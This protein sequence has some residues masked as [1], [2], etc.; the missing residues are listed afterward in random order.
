MTDLWNAVA[1]LLD[2]DVNVYRWECDVNGCD[3][4]PHAGNPSPHG[5]SEQQLPEGEWTTWLLQAGRGFGKSRTGAESLLTLIL[6]HPRTVDDSPTEW[7]VAGA[8][9]PDTREIMVVGPSGL[10][11]AMQRRG[12]Q[13]S[14]NRSNGLITLSSGQRVHL[15]SGDDHDL[16]RGM[17]LAGAWVD[18]V[19]TWRRGFSAW[20]EG[21]IPA[22][23]QRLSNDRPRIIAT[24]TPKA[25]G[26]KLLKSLSGRDD[27]SVVITRGSTFA[28]AANLSSEAVAELRL[29]YPEGSRLWRVE[30]AGEWLEETEGALWS[31]ET[32]DNYRLPSLPDDLLFNGCV[33]AV[34]PAV[35]NSVSSDLTGIVCVASAGVRVDRE[36]YVLADFSVRAEPS[37]WGRR[38]VL[39]AVENNAEIVYESNQ[40]GDAIRDV[41]V[42]AAR[43]LVA[44][45]VI[46]FP[47]AIRPV[48]ASVNKQLRAQPI[49]ALYEVGRVHHVGSLPDL[50]EEMTTWVPSVSKKSP[51]RIDALVHAIASLQKVKSRTAGAF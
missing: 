7:L 46:E 1:D 13:Y 18:E 8:A 31:Q 42:T 14:Y 49:A 50:E 12:V 48:R 40:G 35:S 19:L 27:D 16:A 6:R 22:L 24:S 30:L 9:Y 2:G 32:V 26:V 44:N 39:L 51:D 43:D 34:D 25:V 38:A 3:G 5:R 20:Y 37:V 33:V 17:N 45:M 29:R 15:K 21:L 11:A 28:N 23:R 47:P 41:L 4:L 36:F 10:L